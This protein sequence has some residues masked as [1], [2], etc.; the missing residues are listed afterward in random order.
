VELR[1]K[2]DQAYQGAGDI[3]GNADKAT[4]STG[5]AENREGDD[6]GSRFKDTGCWW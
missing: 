2:L 6:L 3:L 5:M 4:G 1:S